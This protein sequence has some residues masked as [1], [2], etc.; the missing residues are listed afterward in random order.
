MKILASGSKLTAN[1]EKRTN[2]FVECIILECLHF[3]YLGCNI[4][5]GTENKS[6]NKCVVQIFIEGTIL[7]LRVY[8]IT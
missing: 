7:S 5:F 2:I 1:K 4:S 8:F 3:E 6:S